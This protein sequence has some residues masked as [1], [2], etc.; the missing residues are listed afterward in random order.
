MLDICRFFISL[1][2][3]KQTDCVTVTSEPGLCLSFSIPMALRKA[4][5]SARGDAGHH[6]WFRIGMLIVRY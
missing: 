4:I 3:Q 2:L 5:A 1:K 6:G